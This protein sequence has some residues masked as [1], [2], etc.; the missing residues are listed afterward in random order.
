VSL[1]G[2]TFKMGQRGDTVTVRP[3]ALDVTEVTADAYAACVR[4]GACTTDGLQCDA[5]ATYGVNEKRNHPIN[6]VDWDQATAYCRWAGERLPTE[7]EW[8]WAARG[9]SEAR[10][11]PWGSDE[12]GS[13]ACWDRSETCAVGSYPAGDAP[14]GIHDLE[15]EVYE[16]TASSY[17][18]DPRRRVIRGGAFFYSSAVLVSHGDSDL[19]TTRSYFVGFRCA[20]TA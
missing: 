16:W 8:E 7:E 13:R 2:G 1:L 4:A 3:F 18:A 5:T 20:R 15:G 6:C 19:P 9:G 10:K 14:G 17:R 11:Y 12:S